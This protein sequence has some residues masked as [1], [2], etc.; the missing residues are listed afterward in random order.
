MKKLAVF[1][2][3][4]NGV[5]I[6]VENVKDI[7]KFLIDNPDILNVVDLENEDCFEVGD[8]VIEAES[9]F[10]KMFGDYTDEELYDS[11][12]ISS[13]DFIKDGLLIYWNALNGFGELSIIKD[14][15]RFRF[16][17]ELMGKE[18]AEKVLNK[19]VKYLMDNF[20]E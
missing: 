14:N 1:D 3:K 2:E 4:G 11:I 8:V 5:V 16:D 17:T 15:D 13:V 9:D 19:A 7:E 6:E 10:G 12:N 20:S 18:F